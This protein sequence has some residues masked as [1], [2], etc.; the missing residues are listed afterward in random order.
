MTDRSNQMTLPETAG[1]V[2]E[3][4][5]DGSCLDNGSEDAVAA[6]GCVLTASGEHNSDEIG[7]QISF[8]KRAT[9]TLAE[10][11]AVL[12]A[13]ARV[14]DQHS[15]DVVVHV[16]SDSE[17]VVRQL[18]GSYTVRKDHLEEPHRETEEFFNE[19]R[20]WRIEQ[21]SESES[22][23]IQR[24]DELAKAAARGDGQ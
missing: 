2:I 13:L 3:A 8:E 18:Q 20:G 23:Q 7:T 5:V 19:F 11:T 10:Y 12:A 4:Y 22:R 9:S 15:T 14:E 16:Y 6:V 21:R 1:P 17:V 24:A